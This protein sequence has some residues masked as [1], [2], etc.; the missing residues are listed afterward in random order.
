MVSRAALRLIEMG[1]LS[2]KWDTSEGNPRRLLRLTAKGRRALAKA[3]KGG[4]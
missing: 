1:Y 2:G 3:E 4:S